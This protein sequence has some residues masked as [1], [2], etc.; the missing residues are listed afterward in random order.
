MLMTSFEWPVGGGSWVR[1]IDPARARFAGELV[2]VCLVAAVASALADSP[3]GVPVLGG[4]SGHLA[5][6]LVAAGGGAGAAIL[7]DQSARLLPTAADRPF[8]TRHQHPSV[9]QPAVLSRP[10][11]VPA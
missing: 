11:P 10:V 4:E 1:P 6:T 2:L 3:V 8:E 7:A 5:L 9:P